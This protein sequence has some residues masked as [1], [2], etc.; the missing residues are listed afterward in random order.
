MRIKSFDMLEVT[1][2]S[3]VVIFIF[4][5]SNFQG[6]FNYAYSEKIEDNNV[7]LTALIENAD[8]LYIRGQHDDAIKYYDKVLS[9]NPND[10][11]VLNSKGDSLYSLGKYQDAIEYY[12]KVLTINGTD[13]YALI[14]N[15]A[16]YFSLGLYKDALQYYSDALEINGTDTDALNGKAASLYILGQ[17]QDAIKYYGD[18]LEINGTDTYALNG[19]GDSLYKL[20]KYQNALKQFE[21]VLEID[22]KDSYANQSKYDILSQ[23]IS[24]ENADTILGNEGYIQVAQDEWLVDPISIY[25]EIDPS[26]RNASE[27]LYIA[28]KA[29]DKW[30][31]VLKEKSANYS[32]WNFNIRNSI[33]D[34]ILEEISDPIDVVIELVRSNLGGDCATYLGYTELFPLDKSEPV[35]SQV[36]ISCD[37]IF[38][39]KFLP[40]EEAYSTIS[41]EFG[42]VLG[43]GHT[44]ESEGDLMCPGVYEP[45]A[46]DYDGCKSG[47]GRNEPSDLNVNALLYKYGVDGFSSPNRKVKEDSR[48]DFHMQLPLVAGKNHHLLHNNIFNN[49]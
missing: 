17:Y 20:E 41:H 33:D 12:E 5:T 28:S 6:Q 34:P 24:E 23:N 25:V 40:R 1:S 21:T 10:T 29:I 32:A 16:S 3:L 14:S 37:D 8:E 13:T 42:H 31:E 18:A 22:P 30:S 48:F 26:V 39:E 27:Y 45:S 44:F 7:N 46:A 47:K 49:N 35:Y 4:S 36:F 2:F 19:I 38:E 43:L 9:V 15:A 11:Y